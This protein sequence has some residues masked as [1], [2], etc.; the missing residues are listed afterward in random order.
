MKTE[1]ILYVLLILPVNLAVQIN[2]E[3]CYEDYCIDYQGNKY[4]R[5]YGEEGYTYFDNST[6]EQSYSNLYEEKLQEYDNVKA[7]LKDYAYAGLF[8]GLFTLSIWG[9]MSGAIPTV[10]SKIGQSVNSGLGQEKEEGYIK[11]GLKGMGKKIR[12]GLNWK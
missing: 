2:L 4:Q 9:F 12:L 11:K 7:D 10:I 6:N 5:I 1:I 8:I 3:R